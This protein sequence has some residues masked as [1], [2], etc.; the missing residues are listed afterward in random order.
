MCYIFYS[1]WN[2]SVSSRN[3]AELSASLYRVSFPIIVP[4]YGLF[5]V[6]CTML[7]PSAWKIIFSW[8]DALVLLSLHLL[9]KVFPSW[10][11][12]LVMRSSHITL[13]FTSQYQ[14]HI[15]VILDCLST[16]LFWEFW[17]GRDKFECCPFLFLQCLG[18]CLALF[19]KYV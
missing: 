14:F 17:D 13:F 11:L 19:N 12:H 8:S 16:L 18:A 5:S 10:L 6:P 15:Y 1:K 7:P 2:S 3:C 9:M 4:S